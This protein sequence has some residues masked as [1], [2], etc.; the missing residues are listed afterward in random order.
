MQNAV[1]LC[2]APIANAVYLVFNQLGPT[3]FI[4]VAQAAFLSQL[5]PQM[6]SINPNLSKIE[7]V[8]AGAT[9]LRNLALEGEL[10]DVLQA[11]AKSLDVTFLIAAALSAV[12]AVLATRVEWKYV[13]KKR[14]KSKLAGKRA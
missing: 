7:I 13:G 14:R 2:D 3:I 9:G 1:R 12:G 6:Q 8:Q 5:I 4:P 11:Y 10:P